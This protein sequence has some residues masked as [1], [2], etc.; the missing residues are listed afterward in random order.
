MQT[1]KFY[2]H[3]TIITTITVMY[4]TKRKWVDR[5]NVC[6]CVCVVTALLYAY[7]WSVAQWRSRATCWRFIA[8]SPNHQH[9]LHAFSRAS[10]PGDVCVS[11]PYAQ[12]CVCTMYTADPTKPSTPH[13]CKYKSCCATLSVVCV[14]FLVANHFMRIFCGKQR[15]TLFVYICVCLS[16][17][18]CQ[19]NI[20]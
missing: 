15:C 14:C 2:M 7:M 11:L 12:K 16:C 18:Y 10:L 4:I 13:E 20:G 6:V 8:G 5:S 9:Q 1:I 19:V 17:H 3:F